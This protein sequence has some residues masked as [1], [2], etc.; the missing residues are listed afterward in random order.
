MTRVLTAAGFASLLLLTIAA[1]TT[2]KTASSEATDV[3]SVAVQVDPVTPPPLTPR[4][5]IIEMISTG[6]TGTEQCAIMGSVQDLSSRTPLSGAVVSLDNA[7]YSAITADG[8][9]RIDGIPMGQ[10]TVKVEATGYLTLE[11]EIPLGPGEQ[12]GL[13]IGM[14]VPG[15]N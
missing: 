5:Q 10:H 6:N 2:P 1:C 3:D 8:R 15:G 11:Q 7:A 14:V 4:S 13:L 9:F 12:L